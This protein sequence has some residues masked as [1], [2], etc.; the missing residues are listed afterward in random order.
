VRSAPQDA[1]VSPFCVLAREERERW[2]SSRTNKVVRSLASLFS[3]LSFS[4]YSLSLS[5][6]HLR[7]SS[8][9]PS[10]DHRGPRAPRRAGGGSG[11]C[12][13]LFERAEKRH[14]PPLLRPRSSRKSETKERG[15]KNGELRCIS[16]FLLCFSLASMHSLSLSLAPFFP[17]PLRKFNKSTRALLSFFEPRASLARPRS[18][19]RRAK[20]ERER[21]AQRY[22]EKKRRQRKPALRQSSVTTS[23]NFSMPSSADV[24][25]RHASWSAQFDEAR[26]CQRLDDELDKVIGR[27]QVV[28]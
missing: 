23:P 18:K 15:R 21:D 5:L 26:A 17:P 12:C 10:I 22:R 20:E 8:R 11:C 4:L 19:Q 1:R 6:T 28:F 27:K 14:R 16:V 24:D 25:W 13:C 2:E 3:L 7:G 9:Y